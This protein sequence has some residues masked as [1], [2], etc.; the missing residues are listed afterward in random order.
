MP[1]KSLALAI[2]TYQRAEILEDNLRLMAPTL[3]QLGIA[4]YVFDDSADEATAAVI[5]RLASSTRLDLHYR[6]NRPALRHDANLVLALTAPPTDFVWLLGDGSQLDDAGLRAVHSRLGEQD[7]IFVKSRGGAA[8]ATLEH[9]GD[10]ALRRFMAERAWDLSYTG[11]TVY[12]RRVIDWWRSDPAHVPVA[13]F[14]QLS[15]TL[16]FLAAPHQASATWIGSEVVS[17][18]PRKTQSY[19]LDAALSIWGS[20]WHRVISSHRGAFGGLAIGPVLRSHARQTGVLS[21]KHLLVLRAAGKFSRQALQDQPEL[22]QCC[23]VGG[24]GLALL[25]ALPQRAAAAIVALRPS[26]QRRYLPAA[27]R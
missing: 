1:V 2:P 10:A 23:A 19:W 4:V 16:G 18:H 20:D 8:P 9:L 5:E 17:N 27:R 6:H 13:N 14:P 12:G 7:F 3:E 22:R 11:A 15:F 24:F 25:S 21:T 26:W